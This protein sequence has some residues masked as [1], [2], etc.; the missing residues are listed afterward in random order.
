MPRMRATKQPILE[1]RWQDRLNDYV[2]AIAWSPGGQTLAAS[3][4]A[5][6]VVLWSATTAATTVLQ[7][8]TG[9]SIDC[10]N[11]SADGHYLAAAGQGGQVQIWQLQPGDPSPYLTI[12]TARTWVDRLEWN[13]QANQLAFN[14]GR[15]VQV[16][17]IAAREVLMT[18]PFETSSVL[19]LAWH[20]RGERLLVGGQQ[21]LKIW[22]Q[23]DWGGNPTTLEMAAAS[24]TLACSPDGNY[25]ASGNLDRTLLLWQWEQPFPWQMQGFPGKVRQLAWSEPTT[26]AGAPLLASVS[27]ETIVIW[28][29]DLN[30][31]VGWAAQMLNWHQDKVQ[32]IAFQPKS[33][34]LASGSADGYLCLWQKA[35]QVAQVLDGA[36]NGFSCLQWHPTGKKLA[37]GGQNGEL[38]I[39]SMAMQGQG[40]GPR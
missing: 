22:Q 9:Q 38:L 5:G 23:A 40:F 33:L 28:E 30:E 11:F 34:L 17:D 19:S 18:L 29:K 4:A 27:A 20:P 35:K 21:G 8:A 3:S 1:P 24:V 15:T 37:A 26:P 36:P 12:E 13:P 7:L 14:L 16:W 10:L 39:W 2:T 31:Q 32:A 25:F 6:E